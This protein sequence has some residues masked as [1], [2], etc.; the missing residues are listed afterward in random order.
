MIC[1]LHRMLKKDKLIIRLLLFYIRRLFETEANLNITLLDDTYSDIG[2]F[3]F[4]FF[5][6]EK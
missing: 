4:Q 3:V 5:N 6:S 2:L 1:L